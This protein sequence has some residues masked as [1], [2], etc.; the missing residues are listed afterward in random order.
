MDQ[1]G[2]YLIDKSELLNSPFGERSSQHRCIGTIKTVRSLEAEVGNSF[3]GGLDG[4][5]FQ[6]TRQPKE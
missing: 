3:S 2:Q 4:D 1:K 6:F 5:W